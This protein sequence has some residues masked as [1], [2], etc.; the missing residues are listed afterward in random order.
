MLFETVLSIAMLAIVIWD[1]RFLL[2]KASRERDPLALACAVLTGVLALVMWLM[3]GV[4]TGSVSS[5]E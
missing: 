2:P 4:S 3:V 1:V 5:P